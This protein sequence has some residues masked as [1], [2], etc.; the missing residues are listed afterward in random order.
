M[1]V[2]QDRNLTPAQVMQLTQA[3]LSVAAIDG[4]HPAEAALIS[5]FYESSRSAEM[6]AVT[7]VMSEAASA[8][9][10]LQTLANSDRGFADTVV[11][12]CLMCGYADGKLS[13]AEHAHVQKIAMATGL[14]DAAF[15]AH[16]AQVRDELTGAI[17]HLPDAG[18]VAAVVGKL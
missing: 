18:S 8:A 3:M 1:S 4:M 17:S 10:E 2:V 7:S 16:L 13:D 15:Q 9:L 5:D 6:P 12:M 14:D 11:L